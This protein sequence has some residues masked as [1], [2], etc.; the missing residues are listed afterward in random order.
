[1]LSLVQGLVRFVAVVA[2]LSAAA[3]PVAAQSILRDAETEQLLQDMIDPLSEAAGLGYGAVDVVL[4][5]D[6]SINAFVAGGQR[7]Y[8]HSGLIATADTAI[9]VQGVLAHELGHITGGHIIRHSEGAGNATRITLLS[10]L[11]GIAA[12]LAG[13]GEAAMGV[14]ALGQQAAMTS[15]LG[16]RRDQ[17]ASA[18][19]AGVAYLSA[20]GISGR[21]SLEFFRKLQ[22]YEFRRGIPQ[23][24]EYA[25]T[26]PLSGNRIATLRADYEAD[27]AWDAP[28]DP[29]IQERFERIKA[30]LFGY[31]STPER[32]LQAFPVYMTGVPA[33]YARAYAFHKD[34]RVDMA[35]AEAEALLAMEPDNPY[36]LE[37]EGQ[38]LL[39]SGRPLE[40]LDPLRRAVALTGSDPLIAP[41]L[42]H[43]LLAT[44]NPMHLEEA[45]RVL[46]AAVGR[47][48]ENPF[49]WYQLGVVYGQR[50]D[51]PRAQ[52]ASAEQQIMSG[53][54]RAALMSARGAEQGL[55][56]GSPDWIRAQDVGLQARAQIERQEER[57]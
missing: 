57:R 53:N 37:L 42:G 51:I 55:P 10:T 27:A 19:A 31:L 32:T 46:R 18:D 44:E 47:D 41:M 40:A 49:A 15:Y 50:G 1:M 38:I 54:P 25:R 36:F 26:H 14:M 11:A 39:E 13:G 4:I 9:E 20:A 21:G 7:V 5:N 33:R 2:L 56:T 3:T 24:A 43:A 12:A 28:G 22:S 29:Q 34:A 16:F 8:I 45:E 35:L 23:E 30:K 6:N 48:R 52:L 17:E